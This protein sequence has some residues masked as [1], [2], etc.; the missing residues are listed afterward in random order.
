MSMIG[1]PSA[2]I[3]PVISPRGLKKLER[4]QKYLR[5]MY[6]AAKLLASGNTKADVYPK[7]DGQSYELYRYFLS[8]ICEMYDIIEKRQVQ[9]V[10]AASFEIF[11]QSRHKSHID[12]ENGQSLAE[13]AAVMASRYQC[14]RE[15]IGGAA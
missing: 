3:P 4:V 14:W 10:K 8:G 13:V 9:E 2:I 1:K 7:S 5:R 11:H 12:L 6:G 15:P